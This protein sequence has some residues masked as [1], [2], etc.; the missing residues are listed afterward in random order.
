MGAFK[1]AL[2]Q[3][4]KTRIQDY[5]ICIEVWLIMHLLPIID[6]RERIHLFTVDAFIILLIGYTS[7]ID[8]HKLD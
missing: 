8:K 2:A 5:I 6:S 3:E 1:G 7:E 4:L